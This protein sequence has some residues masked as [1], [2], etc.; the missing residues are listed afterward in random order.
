MRTI[1]IASGLGEIINAEDLKAC[2]RPRAQIVE[3]LIARLITRS[4]PH[5]VAAMLPVFAAELRALRARTNCS[6]S[7]ANITVI[8]VSRDFDAAD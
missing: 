3:L 4:D 6:C 7:E 5:D 1:W 8:R 2:N